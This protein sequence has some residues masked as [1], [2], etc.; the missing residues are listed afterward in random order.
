M[1]PASTSERLVWRWYQNSPNDPR[2]IMRYAFEV[3][4]S[5]D[6]TKLEGALHILI[7]RHYPNLQARFTEIEGT[8]YKYYAQAIAQPL[9][10]HQRLSPPAT[11]PEHWTR[12]DHQ[13]GPLY[14]WTYSESN[15]SSTLWIAMSHLVTDGA[16]YEHM[17]QLLQTLTHSDNPAS[18]ECLR[19]YSDP[20]CASS[21]VEARAFWQKQVEG[22]QLSAVV[23][24]VEHSTRN[25]TLPPTYLRIHRELTRHDTGQLLRAAQEH[26][27]TPFQW[28]LACTLITVG[29]YLKGQLTESRPLI[30][31]TVSV[32]KTDSA[33]ACHTNVLPCMVDYDPTRTV[34]EL[35]ADIKQWRRLSRP[36]QMFDGLDIA[37][38]SAPF[39]DAFARPFNVMVTSAEGTLPILTPHL[40]GKPSRLVAELAGTSNADLCV[41]INVG[42]DR[43]R[44]MFECASNGSDPS[45][46]NDFAHH[47]LVALCWMIDNP[48]RSLGEFSVTRA[49]APVSC[50]EPAIRPNEHPLAAVTRH[51]LQ[52]P[53][54]MAV[55]ASDGELS[56]RQVLDATHALAFTLQPHRTLRPVALHLG[57]STDLPVALLAL[58]ANGM[59]FMP[60]ATD[61]D[62]T[63][64]D[65]QINRMGCTLIVC[66]EASRDQLQARHPDKTLITPSAG[67]AHSIPED[68]QPNIDCQTDHDAYWITTSGSS[69]KP[70][71]VIVRQSS[72]FNVL[73]SI[74]DFPGLHERDR[75]LA[76]APV[77]FDIS[78][79]ELLLPLLAGASMGIAPDSVRRDGHAL[80]QLIDACRATVVQ[81]TPST[82]LALQASG[83]RSQQ[84]LRCWVGGEP[85]TAQCAEYLLTQGHVV[86]NVYG[87]TEATIWASA[88]RITDPH[89][90]TLGAPVRG[91][92]FYVLNEQLE[93]VPAGV[94]GELV[95][96][97]TALA[98]GYLENDQQ[99]FIEATDSHPRFYRTGDTVRHDGNG[100]LFFI[101]RSDTQIKISGQRADLT[102]IEQALY[103]FA[104]QTQWLAAVNPLPSPHLC[105][106][107]ATVTNWHPDLRALTQ[108]LNGRLSGYAI[109]QRLIGVAHLPRTAHSKLD[110][111]NVHTLTALHD[112]RRATVP[113]HLTPE[114][115]TDTQTTLTWP[116][117][118]AII[119]QALNIEVEDP[120][121][122]FGWSGINSVSLNRLSWCLTHQHNLTISAAQ[123]I[124]AISPQGLLSKLSSS[125]TDKSPPLLPPVVDAPLTGQKIAIIAMHGQL[126]GARD[127]NDFWQQQLEGTCAISAH[128]R[129][130]LNGDFRAGFIDNIAGFDHGLFRISPRE[131]AQI[132]PRQRRLLQAVWCTLQNAGYTQQ[133]LAGTRTGCYVAATGMDYQA[134]RVVQQTDV[135]SH[136]LQGA[137][138]AMLSNRLSHFFDWHGPSI[139]VDTACS[140]SFAA[141]I[142][143]C[144]DLRDNTCDNAIVGASNLLL[145]QRANTALAMGG[146]LSPTFTC[147]AFSSAANGYVRAEATTAFMLKRHSDA[148][149]DKDPILGLI[150]GYGENHS[151]RTASLTAPSGDAQA[152]LLS[153]LYDEEL[154][155]R[156]G[157]LEPHGTGTLLGD[158]IELGALN[159]TWT[160]LKA[161][162]E[163]P[164][165]L[166]TLKNNIGHCEASAGLAS[167]IKVVLALKH[168]AIPMSTVIAGSTPLEQLAPHFYLPDTTVQWPDA[169]DRIAGISSFGF[170][171]HN[172]HIVVE[173]APIAACEPVTP[174]A[175]TA[176]LY[177]I[178]A[179]NTSSL[180]TLR[181]ALCSWLSQQ[182]DSPEHRLTIA[183]N[184]ALCREHMRYRMAFTAS[185]LSQLTHQLGACSQDANSPAQNPVLEPLRLSYMAGNTPDWHI[186][187]PAGRGRVIAMPDYPFSEQDHWFDKQIPL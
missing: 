37:A 1:T 147:A 128:T 170:G 83:W 90:L 31:H 40:Q 80:G 180:E 155:H 137:S 182:D 158:R 91:S 8:L 39:T 159:E 57:R 72:L 135:Q 124:S 162:G 153:S 23:P 177:V 20:G 76:L 144:S 75:M 160:R 148:L 54:K 26:H 51:A 94:P 67:K 125:Q 86:Y 149:R 64:I 97:G 50:T 98:A 85:L 165:A 107:Y 4:G 36:Y 14:R 169:G 139:T 52:Q 150:S 133:Q 138:A 163:P 134:L 15:G 32:A 41:S 101:G 130:F 96:A 55:T 105:A 187:F 27:V 152:R 102:E 60:I 71:T 100:Q 12:I 115:P 5:L 34:S 123:I 141:L 171:G 184:L 77:S 73:A 46:L 81:A 173:H 53:T 110:R 33:L 179:H 18:I 89:H 43:T 136:W 143:A 13:D 185:S 161:R 69:G 35:L 109:P 175:D 164:I 122:P 156:V 181:H 61:N 28:M 62:A 129:T 42:D 178:S 142:R 174:L 21:C 157:Y 58:L 29:S 45:R 166:G 19:Q 78:L 84:P 146:F 112:T 151:G 183:S 172:A 120:A 114:L 82:W 47:W 116:Q 63:R 48:N 25:T 7:E 17:C 93:S 113:T 30:A 56:Y 127:L 104:P 59:P 186:V 22:R 6:L 10:H 70:K 99:G 119:T 168:N 176:L 118:S 106:Y 2:L 95:I 9:L 16:V 154:A 49:R 131:A 74:R 92:R 3:Q 132:D 87:P 65:E 167:L 111:R 11:E 117:L 126:P 121:L 79:L 145:D 68:W 103:E 108:H 140:S 66:D 24:F 44:L 88:S 38:M